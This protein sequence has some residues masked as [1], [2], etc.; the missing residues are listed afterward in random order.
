[1]I[2][3]DAYLSP[4]FYNDDDK[5]DKIHELWLPF[6]Y[7]KVGAPGTI[8]KRIVLFSDIMIGPFF[9]IYSP[10]TINAFLLFSSYLDSSTDVYW[11]HC[12]TGTV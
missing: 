12:P 6:W 7:D 9:D 1:M 10:G 4:I 5:D 3:S 8:Y 2:Y 11:L